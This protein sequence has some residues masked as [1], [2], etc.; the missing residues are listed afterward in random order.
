MTAKIKM[1]IRRTKVKLDKAPTVLAMMV[2]ISLS[3]FQ[4][5]ASLNTRSNRNDRNI[6]RP[7]T[8]SANNSTKDSTTIMKSKMFHPS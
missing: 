2:R 3:D 7:S 1:M 6:D 5:L 8:P 4:D